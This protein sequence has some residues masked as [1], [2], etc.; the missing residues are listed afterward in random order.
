MANLVY[1][2]PGIYIDENASPVPNIGQVTA[3]PPSRVA[4]VGPSIGYRT[5]IETIKLGATAITLQ[6]ARAER[7]TTP[8]PRR[9][10]TS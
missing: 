7:W 5:E 3:L 8:S 6:N 10:R 9:G 1:T 4:I 2:P